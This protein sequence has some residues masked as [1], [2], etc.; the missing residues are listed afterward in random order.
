MDDRTVSIGQRPPVGPTISSAQLEHLAALMRSGRPLSVRLDGGSIEE[1]P[2][3]G[4]GVG[5]VFTVTGQGALRSVSGVPFDHI[6]WP[7]VLLKAS[8]V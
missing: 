6:A 5:F 3:V 2:V 4:V 7:Q 1:F 8:E